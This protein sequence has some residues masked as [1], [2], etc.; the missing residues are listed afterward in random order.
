MIQTAYPYIDA[1]LLDEIVARLRVAHLAQIIGHVNPDG[2]CIGSMLAMHRMLTLWGVPHALAAQKIGSHGYDQLDGFELIGAEPGARPDLVVYLDTA[3]LDRGIEGWV[4]AVPVI[5]ID[6]HAGNTRFGLLNWIEPRFCATGEMIFHLAAHAGI[7]L[8]AGMANDLL[9]AVTTDTGSFRYSNTGAD[10]H[11]VAAQ[12]IE[13]GASPQ[14]VARI[15]YD[16]QPL[17]SLRITG[18]VLSNLKIEAGGRLA[19]SELRIED[20]RGFGGSERAPEN[21]VSMLRSVRGVR[22]CL[23]FHELEGGRVRVNFRSDGSIDVSRLA[24]RW[25][26][27]GHACAAGLLLK[28]AGDYEKAR[29]E[30]IRATEEAMG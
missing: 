26:G 15:A 12:L 10:Q 21:L 18:H 22:V 1:Q 13:A 7:K 30:T 20:C 2:D 11:R 19:W 27:G 6:H 16:S 29:D 14:A 25:G 24:A 23:L 3:T 9:L 5:N 17:E 8:S 28:N 4:P